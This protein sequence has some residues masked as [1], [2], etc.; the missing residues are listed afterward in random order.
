M[1]L[2]DKQQKGLELA[3]ARFK[4]RKPYTCIAGLAGSGKTTLVKFIISALNLDPSDVAYVAFT[5]KA[6][7]VLSRKGNPNATTAHR[8]LYE[9]RP[10]KDG[11]FYFKKREFLDYPYELI[12][13]DEVSMLPKDMWNLLLSHHIPVIACGDPGQLPPIDPTTNNHVL[14]EPHIFLDEIMRQAAES[15]IIQ[16]SMHVR[17]GK[18]LGAFEPA[19]AQVKILDK[20][21]ITTGLYDWADQILCAT[22]KTRNAINQAIRNIKGFGLEPQ[23]GD[24]VI[25]MR[26]NWDLMSNTQNPLTNGT[27]GVLR[28]IRTDIIQM[29]YYICK[30]SNLK[31]IYADV[32]TEDEGTFENIMIDYESLV[33]GVKALDGRQEYQMTQNKRL[34]DPPL[35]FAYGYAITTHKAQGSEWEK[36]LVL[37]ER[38]PFE[39]EE[40]KRWIYTACTRASDKLVVVK[41]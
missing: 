1:I 6:A 7:N 2:T 11:T 16:L 15:E 41:K 28:N 30:D 37:E 36:V 27:T 38:F 17:N 18:T 22:N 31:V 10:K 33:K 14:D 8:L 40:H 32:E 3:V 24:K 5:G 19:G 26:N 9:A 12:V 29:P 23:E 21:D 20:I 39:Q 13:V 25:A 35:E 34:P 4:E